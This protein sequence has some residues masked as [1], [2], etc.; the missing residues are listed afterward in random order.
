MTASVLPRPSYRPLR[1]LAA[2]HQPAHGL[3]FGLPQIEG[4]AY[5]AHG[6]WNAGFC[7]QLMAH[8][9]AGQGVAI[10]INANQPALIDELRR[11]G[12]I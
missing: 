12:V 8:Q 2:F 7:A 6:G 11:A 3:G 9:S 4:E 5:F 10:M 1:T